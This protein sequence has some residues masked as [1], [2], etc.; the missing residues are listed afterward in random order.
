MKGFVNCT[1]KS[2]N[3]CTK[4][5]CKELVGVHLVEVIFSVQ[6]LGGRPQILLYSFESSQFPRGKECDAE[7]FTH[8]VP[9]DQ[10]IHDDF[11][12]SQKH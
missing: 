3:I 1:R 7:L 9:N 10:K 2:S 4:I 11:W 6:L 5:L 8:L 12:L